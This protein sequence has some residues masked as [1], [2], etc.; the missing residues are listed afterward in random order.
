[1][2]GLSYGDKPGLNLQNVRDVIIDVP[3]Q[4][5]RMKILLH[6]RKLP[7]MCDDLEAW[8]RAGEEKAERLSAAFVSA[9]TVSLQATIS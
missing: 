9:L 5:L 4:E 3:P 8:L 6:A 7:S 2:L 1:L